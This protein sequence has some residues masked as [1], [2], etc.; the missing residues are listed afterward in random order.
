MKRQFLL[1][2]LLVGCGEVANPGT[3]GGTG[4]NDG[5]GVGSDGPPSANP[6]T[7]ALRNGCMVNLRMEESKWTGVAGEVKDDCGGDN[8]GTARG[9]GT[10]TVANGV[11]GRAASFAGAGCVEIPNA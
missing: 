9:V 2:A 11:R 5:G 10:D 6:L 8:A 4:P 1:L 7:G 3:D